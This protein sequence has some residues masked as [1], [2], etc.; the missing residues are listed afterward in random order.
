MQQD[1]SRRN[2]A[3]LFAIILTFFFLSGACGLVY[4]VVWTRKLVLLFGT[5]SYAVSTVLS[6][7]FL[8]LGLGSLWGG[9][10]ADRTP[11][12]LGR[13]GV[14]EIMIG[15]W[16]VAFLLM[17][18]YGE[19]LVVAVLRAF[20]FSRGV[21]IGLRA[22]MATALLFVPVF[23]MGATL[24]L[25]SRFATRTP[26]VRAFPIGALYTL[27]TLGAVAGCFTA[28]FYLIP[29]FGYTRAT[30]IAAAVN[31]GIG[32][33]S[34]LLARGRESAPFAVDSVESDI[35][36]SNTRQLHAR[37]VLAAF[38]LSGFCSLAM[39]VLWTR[40]LTIVFLGTTYAYTTM[41]TTLLCGIALGSGFA[42]YLSDRFRHTLALLGTALG[43]TGVGAIYLLHT[44][45]ELPGKY[46]E[47]QRDSGNE[48]SD[49]MQGTVF[50]C[51]VTL[52]PTTFFL[53]M[54][55][56]LVVRAIASQR[57][58]VGSD[59]GRLYFVNTMG[60]VLGAIAG[61]YILIPMLGTQDGIEVL[62]WLL[63]LTGLVL[64][65]RRFGTPLWLDG[66]CSVGILVAGGAALLAA[67]NDVNEDLTLGYIP[68]EHRI[69]LYEEE[70]E[71]TVAV[72]APID[73]EPG[74]DRVLWI[75]RVQATTSIER[76]VRMNRLQGAMPLLFE[77]DINNVL[78][79]CFGSGITC[80]TLALSDFDHIDAVEISPG[81]LRAA[82]LFEKDNLGVI[83][84]PKM[85]FHIDDGRNYLLTT[86][87]EYD[88]ITFEPMPLAL[89]GVSTFYTQDYYR[90]C[91]ERL[92]PGGLV[93]QW[94]PLHS[95]N[96]EVVRSL[97]YTFTTV[98]PHYNAW[99]INADLF[100]IGSNEALRLNY[101]KAVQ[102][103]Q[104]P[105]LKQALNDVAF[106]DLIEL[107]SCFMLDQ[108]GVD[109]FAQGGDVMTD[110]RPWAEFIAP[111][112]VYART[113]HE[114]MAAFAHLQK[115]PL[116]VFAT[117]PPAEIQAQITRRFE[118]R[119]ETIAGVQAYYGGMAIDRS[120]FDRFLA[121]LKI[122]PNDYTARY[123]LGEIARLQGQ[124]RIQWEEFDKAEALLTDA[125]QYLPE[126]A[127]LLKL[128]QQA[129]E[130]K[131]PE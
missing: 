58:H 79:M 102:R 115:N 73:A 104:N 16:A 50:Y 6:I 7:F 28:G 8:G 86:E 129:R 112:L 70:V 39:E 72:S 98:F 52:L 116:E 125:V 51:F 10:W 34:L 120:A 126:D 19:G 33:A 103:M 49:V 90:L 38:F 100:L 67:P 119:K 85:Q 122:D 110:D 114:S 31:G 76:G 42:S 56:P 46:L 95:L 55:F 57:E 44:L 61:G 40:L 60:G 97:V 83:G 128:L 111:K 71:G 47:L 17:V 63:G 121:A 74:H 113:Q 45:S 35:L 108:G 88:L 27:N 93:S 64:L 9:R 78:F 84:N 11:S 14:L 65:S 80:G 36:P 24:P 106:K 87:N 54:T 75:N 20:D 66:L 37:V 130:K 62:A 81:V 117:P 127:T 13:Y 109:A 99:F 32:V 25:L 21:G 43:L 53:G 12:P 92:T 2:A 105:V 131:P 118:A 22:L 18:G 23:C 91:L 123:Y 96:P 101:G 5:T 30:L 15:L 77:H 48:W 4:Q 41:L 89:A 3:L 68:E 29:T 26:T 94:V 69:L 124:A 1:T 59:V 107:I 82:P